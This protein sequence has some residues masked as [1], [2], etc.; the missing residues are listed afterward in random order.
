M[1]QIVASTFAA[2]AISVALFGFT[3]RAEALS[4]ANPGIAC[5]QDPNCVP[6]TPAPTAMPTAVLKSQLA[7]LLK[8]YRNG[9]LM[10]YVLS[11]TWALVAYGTVNN[12]Y[13]AGGGVLLASHSYGS[14]RMISVGAGSYSFYDLTSRGVDSSS[15]QV[16]FQGE[17]SI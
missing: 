8:Q 9:P 15:A 6:H 2:V 13:N 11:S 4:G 12:D 1:N 3:P 10:G 7:A 17:T 16:L 5:S 14:W